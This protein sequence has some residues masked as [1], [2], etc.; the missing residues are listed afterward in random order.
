MN[1]P[2]FN[3]P[4]QKKSKLPDNTILGFILG[5][6]FPVIGICILYFFWGDGSFEGYISNFYNTSSPLAMRTASKIMSLSMFT[7]LI[8]FN[9]FINRKK[10]YSTRGIILATSI[11]AIL[12]ILYNFVWQ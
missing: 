10:Y 6:I 8:P 1:D 5:L 4:S 12:I 7:M 2:V 3:N 9:I 11:F